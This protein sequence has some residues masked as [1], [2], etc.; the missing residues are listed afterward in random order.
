MKAAVLTDYHKIEWREVDKPKINDS[1]VLIKVSYAGI[2]GSD[3]HI[4]NGEFHPRTHLPLIQGHEFAGTIVQV[5]KEVTGF[6]V[7]R[8]VA[9]DPIL[10]CGQCAA[11]EVGHWPGCSNLKL[12]GVD[13]DGGFGEYVAVNASQ[14][15][16]LGDAITDQQGAMVEMFSIGFHACNRAEIKQGDTVAIFSAGRI[17]QTVLQACRT[18]TDNTVFIVDVLPS[19]LQVAKKVCEAAVIINAIEQNPVDII[20]QHTDGKGVDIAFEAVGHAIWIPERA[21]PVAE[22]IETV[23]GGGTVCLLGQP[24]ESVALPTRRIVQKEVKIIASRVSHGEFKEVIQHTSAGNLEPDALVSCEMPASQAQQ[25]FELLET[26]PDN[27]LKIL[28]KLS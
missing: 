8:R 19:R 1:E 18:K 6:Q 5:G 23:R 10:W 24:S 7:G 26:Q 3:Q 12:V 17:G 16:E 14:L 21:H 4:F 20:N 13:L 11:C 15:Y 2:C 9:V 25:A 27:Y 28:L 22:C